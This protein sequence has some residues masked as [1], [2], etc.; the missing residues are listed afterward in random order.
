MSAHDAIRVAYYRGLHAALAASPNLGVNKKGAMVAVGTSPD[1][2]VSFCNLEAFRGR[3]QVAAINSSSSITLSGDEDAIEEAIEIFKDEGKFAR[4]LKV[5]R[6]AFLGRLLGLTLP[7]RSTQP[8][9]LPTCSVAQAHTRP[10]CRAA[11]LNHS[12]AAVQRGTP[13]S[14]KGS[15]CREMRCPRTIGST[16]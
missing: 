9:T 4:A 7:S 1:D 10:R 15:P 14:L 13:A 8:I 3:I 6:D 5:R 2:A 16:T 11:E 12:T